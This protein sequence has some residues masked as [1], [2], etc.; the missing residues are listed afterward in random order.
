MI[1]EKEM[2]WY[3]DFANY[4]V[5]GLLPLDYSSQQKKRFLHDV[6]FYHWD[7]PYIFKQCAD[8]MIRRCIPKEEMEPILQQCHASP[9]RGHFG[10]IQTANKVLQSGL[11][12]PSLF[13]D[14]HTFAT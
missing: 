14:A 12:W 3:V 9:Y 8:Q 10:G 13:K 7:E 11:Y 5:S 6:R 4:L 2:P 1:S